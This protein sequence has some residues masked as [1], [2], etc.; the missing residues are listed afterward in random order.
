VQL[1]LSDIKC[2]QITSLRRAEAIYK[3]PER[4]IRRRRDGK[5]SRRDCEPNSKSLTKLEEEVIVQRTLD[6]NLR[7]VPPSKLHVRDMADRLLRNRSGKSVGKNWVDRFIKRTPELRTRWSRPYDHQRA[8][9]EDAATIRPWFTLVQNMKAK[10][11]IADEDIWNFDESG[12]IMGKIS[13]QLVVTGVEKPGKQK[14][15]QPGDREWVTLVQGVSATGRVIPPFLIFAGKVLITS[16][17]ADLPRDWII[18]VSPTGWINNDLA[19]AWLKHFD[20]H[21]K[22]SSAGAYRLLIIDGHESHC[23]IE[24][25]DYCKENKIIALCMP[26]HSSHLLQPLDVVPYSLLK[27]HYGDGISLLARSRIHHINK[28][29]FLPAFKAAFKKTFTPENVRA[30]FRGAGLVPYDPEAV[31]SKLDVQLRTPTP[32][33]PGTVAWEAQTPRNA[34]EIEAQ[35]TLI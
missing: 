27:R 35:S 20:A 10:H 17:F 23:S 2:D 26:P 24:F 11:G 5:P 19:L 8:V 21:T 14:K 9:C 32:P 7:G 13:S 15:L 1:A 33:A 3:V 18:T 31:L 16:W 30:G 29:T 22:A 6:E 34:R 4:T 12:F 25:Q 28:E